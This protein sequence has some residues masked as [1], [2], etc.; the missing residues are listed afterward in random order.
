MALLRQFIILIPLTGSCVS[1]RAFCG[2][3]GRRRT[4]NPILA[5]GADLGRLGP[6]H[7]ARIR[8][9]RDD[10]AGRVQ[11]TPYCQHLF[12][13][14]GKQEDRIKVTVRLLSVLQTARAGT[15][16]DHVACR[17]SYHFSDLHEAWM[18]CIA[19]GGAPATNRLR[20]SSDRCLRGYSLSSGRDQS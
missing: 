18:N 1:V 16:M 3:A 8:W 10:S 6:R 17:A 12:V 5:G 14:R 7:A 13:F 9:P 19:L 2:C 4:M 11:R 15:H 20:G